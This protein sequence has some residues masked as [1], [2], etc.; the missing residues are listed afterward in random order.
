MAK[1]RRKSDKETQEEYEFKPPEFDE[2]GFIEKELR[3][4][5]T[6]IFTVVYAVV[7]GIVA[8]I[9]SITDRV[10]IGPAFLIALAGMFSLPWIYPIF[11]IDSKSFQK[12][13]WLGNV[14][15]FFFTFLAIWILLLNQPFGDFAKPTITDVTVWVERPGNVTALDYKLSSTTGTYQ[16]QN[17]YGG[18]NTSVV[19]LIHAAPDY[20]LNL[21]AKV[22]DNDGLKYAQISVNGGEYQSMTFEGKNRWGLKINGTALSTFITAGLSF[23]I[24]AEDDTGNQQI[25]IPNQAIPVSP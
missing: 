6:V 10:L 4:T 8:G 24:A 18:S 22:A 13:N 21:T 14:G 12:R 23:S 3:D 1:K 20:S 11:K 2:K 7:L 9:L 17:R 19:G 16:W 25:F 15:T 5:R